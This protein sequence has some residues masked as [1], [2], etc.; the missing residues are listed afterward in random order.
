MATT[1]G[2]QFRIIRRDQADASAA[3]WPEGVQ[4]IVDRRQGERRVK[5]KPRA[6]IQRR[7]GEHRQGGWMDAGLRAQGTLLVRA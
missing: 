2:A 5:E 4:I 3:A 1:R 7:P 6:A